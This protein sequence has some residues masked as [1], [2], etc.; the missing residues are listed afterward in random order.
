[1]KAF[2][3][4]ELPFEGRSCICSHEVAVEIEGDA[5]RVCCVYS[6]GGWAEESGGGP[7]DSLD[8]WKLGRDRVANEVG[9]Q[10]EGSGE[11]D[12]GRMRMEVAV[13]VAERHDA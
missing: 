13:D 7:F 11:L 5:G 6:D 1:M 12:G 9:H 8:F 3:G 4:G 10:I 2:R